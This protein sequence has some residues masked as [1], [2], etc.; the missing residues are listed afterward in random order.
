[1]APADD[2]ALT[3]GTAGHIDHGK[4]ALVE[5]LTG[6]N[7]DRL[8]EEQ[9]RGL[10][11]ELGFAELRLPG[12]KTMGVVDVPG[13]ERLVRTMVAGASGIDMYLLVLAADEGA[14]PQTI[15]HLAVLR[16]LSVRRGV[17]A[18]TKCDRASP[19]TRALAL[20]EAGELV[21]G[22]PVVAVSARTGE[23]L[24]ELRRAL[25]EVAAE[26]AATGDPQREGADGLTVLHVDR[27]FT[28][29]GI[30]TVVTGTLWSGELRAGERVE[31]LPSGTTPRVRSL[32]VHNREVDLGLAG[33]RVALNLAG[34]STDEVRRGD[35]VTVPGSSLQ[36]SYRADVELRLEPAT[37][38]L[39][40]KR[41]QAHHGTRAA[42]ARVIDLG[43]GLAQLRL[44]SPLMAREGDRVLIRSIA[45]PD[46]L[47]G[48]V[49]LD[50]APARH[51]AGGATERLRAI[52]DHG[53]A[54]VLSDERERER[55][56][57]VEAAE[58]RRRG[59]TAP[60]S[61]PLHARARL[62]L[63]LLEADGPEPRTPRAV[64]ERLGMDNAE[65]TAVLDRLGAAGKAVRAAKD[66]YFAADILE[67]LRA[68]AVALARERGELTLAEL[69]DALGTS[70]KYA[71]ALL[72]Y[73]DAVKVTVRH[74]DR[75]VLRDPNAR[76]ATPSA[77]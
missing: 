32:Q 13:H 61:E 30:G 31:V 22:A 53:L 41:V 55:R 34:V 67:E 36:P 77:L 52:R 38:P 9:R 20:E 26:V 47:G 49:V 29:H 69:R 14:M 59:A 25:G 5:A 19:E 60:P 7:T 44:E 1:M 3:L 6:T 23:G 76:P 63:A 11:I 51:G 73:L 64:G 8:A 4:T 56:R 50:P 35:V 66:V 54:S 17:V 57:A 65:A 27:S 18:V 33:Q 21:P 45:P 10:S 2:R 70:R 46:T 58:E 24:D 43:Q 37:P 72:E 42:P 40:G 16:G 71:Q 75:H 15:E 62:V 48:A 68:K 12:G 39:G 74:G 28:L